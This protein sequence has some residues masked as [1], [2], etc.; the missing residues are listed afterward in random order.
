MK[1]ISLLSV[2][3]YFVLMHS[4][5]DMTEQ[6]NPREIVIAGKVINYDVDSGKNILTIY[7]NDNGRA[8]QLNFPTRIDSVGNF[9]VKFERYYPQDVMISYRT[10][11]RVIVHPGDSLYVEFDGKTRQRTKI[12]ETVKYSGDGATINSQLSKYLITYFETR[13]SSTLIQQNERQLNPDDYKSFQDSIRNAREIHRDQ[14][15]LDN[16]PNNELVN[17][18]NTDIRLSYFD[19]LLSYPSSHKRSNK[20]PRD[21]DIGDEYYDFIDTIQPVTIKSLVYADTRF[22]INQYLYSYVWKMAWKNADSKSQANYDSLILHQILEL[23][24]DEGLVKQLTLNEYINSRFSKYEVSLYEKNVELINESITENF[25]IEPIHQH[26]EE[27][28]T[29]IDKPA[30]AEEI[31]INGISENNASEIWSKILSE[32]KGKVIY[33]DCWATWC[34]A[35]IA[36]FPNSN[37]MMEAYKDKDVEFVYFC[38]MSDEKQWKA[39]LAEKKMKGQHYFLDDEQS[40]YFVQLLKISGYPTYAIIDKEGRV[41]RTG[42]SFRP[43]RSNTEKIID[44]LLMAEIG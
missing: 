11:F 13:P 7:I 44:E 27:I 37:E 31:E 26:Y 43:A 24:P 28:R 32:N 33:L 23:S 34:G 1:N 6:N 18:I 16:E 41:I 22:F 21:W 42:S 12:F 20:L 40:A 19:N 3:F 15:I 36:E 8:T 29:Y 30:L 38:L 2:V 25:L 17:W 14:F 39:V 10:N 35:C 4:C 5:T 9:H